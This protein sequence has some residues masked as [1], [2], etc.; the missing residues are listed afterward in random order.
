MAKDSEDHSRVTVPEAHA[1]SHE[2]GG[3]DEINHSALV[4]H[5]H[6]SRHEA[7]G[8]DVIDVS[9]LAGRGHQYV[10]RGDPAAPDLIQSGMTLDS[11][12]YDWDLSSIVPAGAVAVELAVVMSNDTVGKE[13]SFRKNG[14]TNNHNALR[15]KQIVANGTEEFAGMVSCDS[16]RVIEYFGTGGAVTWL[17]VQ[18]AV[19]GWWI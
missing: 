16:S 15:H 5:N 8:P 2:A 13:L 6:A 1:S 10:D 17:V 3:S 14:N 18:V 4:P 11:G 7:G 12:W 9:G 19:R